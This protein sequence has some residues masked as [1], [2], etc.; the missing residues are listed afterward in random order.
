M[1]HSQGQGELTTTAGFRLDDALAG[2]KPRPEEAPTYQLRDFMSAR[3]RAAVISAMQG[4]ERA[5]FFAKM[6]ELAELVAK[7]PATYGQDVPD[8]IAY[9]HYFTN[10]ADFFITEKDA[11]N[12]G[13]G[14]AQAY[15]LADLF[16]DGGEVGY[17]SIREVIECG[18]ELDFHFTP[19]PLSEVRSSRS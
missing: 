15:G 4:E 6:A 13:E 19:R 5:W 12:D 1:D 3:Q 17:I 8:P 10:G 14:Q 9:L 16:G 7:M 11:A 2:L 18:A